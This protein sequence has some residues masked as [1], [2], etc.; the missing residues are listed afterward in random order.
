MD[1]KK[2]TMEMYGFKPGEAFELFYEGLEKIIH[3]Q[4]V[5]DS[6]DAVRLFD[7]SI[8]KDPTNKHTRAF[9]SIAFVDVGD[10][11]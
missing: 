2:T 6:I 5:E 10:N 3:A 1:I 9:R 8:E 7:K 4:S 11:T